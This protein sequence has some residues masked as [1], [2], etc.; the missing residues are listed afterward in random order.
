MEL[1]MEE[2]QVYVHL[3][4]MLFKI[5]IIFPLSA[6]IFEIFLILLMLEV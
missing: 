4:S 6:L 3:A 1:L 2:S 5:I